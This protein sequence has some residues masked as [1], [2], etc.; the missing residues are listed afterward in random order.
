MLTSIFHLGTFVLYD[1]LCALG[2]AL[3]LGLI[4]ASA[5]RYRLEC[6]S[7][8]VIVLAIMPFLVSCV[9]MIINGNLGTSIAVLGA[10]G[11]VRFRSAPGSGKDITFLFFALV[12]GLVCGLGF[13]SLALV[14][15]ALGI[16]MILV[17]E[18]IRFDETETRKRSLKIAIPEDLD[19]P[20]LFDDLFMVYTSFHHFER[21]RTVNMGTMYELLYKIEMRDPDKEKEFIDALRCRNGNLA[22]SISM[23]QK[24][25][26]EL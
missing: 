7:R 8:F 22:I 6:S 5:Y 3:S 9:I 14:I 17:L 2:T 15:E 13:L 21:V 20:G 10:F 26:N 23:V 24:E 1:V 12:L 11:L 18:M 16:A 4:L 19:Y 25:K